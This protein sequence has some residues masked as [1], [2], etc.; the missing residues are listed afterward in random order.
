M[1]TDHNC[2]RTATLRAGKHI[3]EEAE[4]GSQAFMPRQTVEAGIPYDGLNC[5]RNATAT[6]RLI[7]NTLTRH[8]AQNEHLGT[9]RA[10]NS[11]G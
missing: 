5:I 1:K 10:A 2:H 4:K 9:L 8:L 7:D 3:R 11:T 6:Q